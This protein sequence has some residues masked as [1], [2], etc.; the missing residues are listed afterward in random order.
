MTCKNV[1][2]VNV[3]GDA[4][5]EKA[6]V[7][8]YDRVYLEYAANDAVEELKKKGMEVYYLPKEERQRWRNATDKPVR[9]AGLEKTGEAGKKLLEQTDKI[10]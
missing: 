3:E 6:L 8:P 9:Q 1:V 10:Q 7:I 2:V 4:K 5:G